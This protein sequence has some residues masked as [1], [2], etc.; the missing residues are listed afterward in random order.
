MKS[1][2]HLGVIPLAKD[3][4]RSLRP[5]ERLLRVGNCLSSSGKIVEKRAV[6][7]S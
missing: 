1:L 5:F 7:G 3:D 6:T 2:V 4:W